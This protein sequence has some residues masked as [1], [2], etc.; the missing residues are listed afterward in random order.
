MVNEQENMHSAQELKWL[1]EMSKK[2]DKELENIL[3]YAADGIGKFACD[4]F[5][6]ILYYNEGL[7]TLV[8]TTRGRIEKEGFNS[9]LY[10]HP[11]DLPYVRETMAKE[12]KTRKAFNM[13]YRLK[14]LSGRDVWV[15][16]IGVFTKELY[17]DVYPVIYLIYTD[18]TEL[19]TL[20]QKL[21]EANARLELETDRYKTFTELS[22]ETFFEY[23]T[24]TNEMILFGEKREWTEKIAPPDP[25]K[26]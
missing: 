5:F 1:I 26:C 20:N 16:V 14:H 19:V 11:D 3:G 17:Q 2:K 10:I 23:N 18:I 8:G 7:A 15:K 22:S 24:D 12:I 21:A 25:E 6:T 9:S 13:H 4:P